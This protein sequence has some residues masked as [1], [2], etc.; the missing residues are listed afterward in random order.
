M[1]CY[2]ILSYPI[3]SYPTLFYSIL[4][5][6]ILS[7]APVRPSVHH[8]LSGHLI[9]YLTLSY[10]ILSYPSVYP[11][12]QPTSHP[13]THKY[14]VII[15]SKRPLLTCK[16][17]FEKKAPDQGFLIHSVFDH[18]RSLCENCHLCAVGVVFFFTSKLLLGWLKF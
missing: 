15:E 13:P 8:I 16:V 1:L 6:P 14:V 3:P 10:F 5:Y 7:Y 12:S 9:F 2:P 11:A 17:C 4:S 18:G